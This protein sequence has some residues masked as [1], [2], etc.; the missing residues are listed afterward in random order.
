LVWRHSGITGDLVQCKNATKLIDAA[1]ARSASFH[2]GTQMGEWRGKNVANN[3]T[4]G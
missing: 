2:S 3:L 1:A 4:G